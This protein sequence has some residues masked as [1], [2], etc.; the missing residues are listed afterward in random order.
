MKCFYKAKV[1]KHDGSEHDINGSF[2]VYE[3]EAKAIAK[4]DSIHIVVIDDH[5]IR[6]HALVDNFKIGE[7]AVDKITI[8]D[9]ELLA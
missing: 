8:L 2:D 1:F 7:T 5:T 4:G 6:S 3:D 9:W